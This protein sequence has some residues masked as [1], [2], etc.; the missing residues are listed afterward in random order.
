MSTGNIM[1]TEANKKPPCEDGR[2]SDGKTEQ[3]IKNAFYGILR[4]IT[5]NF[6][7]QKV[8][9]ISLRVSVSGQVKYIIKLK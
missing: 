6:D 1:K 2:K 4:A 8:L 9:L 7:E 3:R 5:L